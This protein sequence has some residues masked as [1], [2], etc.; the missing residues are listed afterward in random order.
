MENGRF[1]VKWTN[2]FWRA[3]DTVDYRDME[4]F[5]LKTDADEKVAQVNA[6]IARES[7]KAK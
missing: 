4:L 2:G 3:F 6:R 7:A 1:V 5:R